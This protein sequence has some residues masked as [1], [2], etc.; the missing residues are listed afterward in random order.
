[1]SRGGACL[2][3]AACVLAPASAGAGTGRPPAALSVSPARVLL[4]G[5]GRQ[6]VRVRNPGSAAVAVAA[7]PA[8]FALTLRGRPRIVSDPHDGRDVAAWLTLRPR[9]LVVAP[10]GT[11]TLTVS[12]AVPSHAEPGDHAALVLLSSR[13]PAGSVAVL[14]RLGVLVD[15]R[16]SGAIVRHL[17]LRALH[18][19]REGRFRVLE[20]ALAN[21]GN[22]T[23]LLQRGRVSV[24]LARSRRVF[25]R[26][27]A[28]PRELLPHSRGLAEIDYRGRLR[29][30]F[31]ARVLVDPAG[32]GGSV[33]RRTFRIRL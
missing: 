19:R 3:A 29:G 25:A 8:G 21:M 1:M 32:P 20:L 4:L 6:A 27:V 18:V 33:W 17:V 26:L 9:R 31:A 5:A 2:A 28:A 12:A 30:V 7:A 23:E 15:V 14:M 13:G 10:G 16:V 11:A 22:V 24:T